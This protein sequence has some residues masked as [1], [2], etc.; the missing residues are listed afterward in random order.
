MKQHILK[1]FGYTKKNALELLSIEKNDVIP[2]GVSWYVLYKLI[3]L[4]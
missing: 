3:F 1:E 4:D 2:T